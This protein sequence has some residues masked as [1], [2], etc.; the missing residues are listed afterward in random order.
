MNNLEHLA[1][2]KLLILGGNPETGVLVK[3]AND[4]GVYTIVADPNPESP[5]KVYAKK[6]YNIDGFDIPKIGRAYV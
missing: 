1:G 3:K 6:H 5:A 4:L 2:K